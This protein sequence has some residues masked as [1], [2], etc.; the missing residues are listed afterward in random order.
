MRHVR[1]SIKD[2]DE[3]YW[4]DERTLIQMMIIIDGIRRLTDLLLP[5]C[6]VLANHRL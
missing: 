1:P 2:Y 3:P 6:T 5:A 4:E